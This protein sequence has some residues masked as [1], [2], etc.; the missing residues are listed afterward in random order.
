M[1][2]REIASSGDITRDEIDHH[3]EGFEKAFEKALRDLDG[4]KYAGQ[5]LEVQA[6]VTI[7]QN[8][9]GVSQYRVALVPTG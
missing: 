1:G 8:P 6:F 2:E 3:G 7:T 9:G 4:Q 5:A